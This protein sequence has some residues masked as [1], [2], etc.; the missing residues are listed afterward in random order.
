MIFITWTGSFWSLHK[1]KAVAQGTST[2]VLKSMQT[3]M[4]AAMYREQCESVSLEEEQCIDC[5]TDTD[6][7]DPEGST[8]SEGEDDVE[9]DSNRAYSEKSQ[10]K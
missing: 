1:A 7:T 3:S 10:R 4:A 6:A 8:T 9:E 2:A 5:E